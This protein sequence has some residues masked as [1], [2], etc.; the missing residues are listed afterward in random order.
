MIE[1]EVVGPNIEGDNKELVPDW[2]KADIKG[3]HDAIEA[4]DWEAELEGKSGIEKWEVVKRVIQEETDRCVPK[5]MRRVGSKPL[6]MN[7]N[8]LRLIRKKR[9]MWKAYSKPGGPLPE[10]GR[11]GGDYNSYSAY[12]KVQKEVQDSVKRAKKKLER[13]LAKNRKKNSKSFY[14][15]IKK[16]TKNKVTIGPL[17]DGDQNVTDSEHMANLLNKWYCSVFTKENLTNIPNPE[18]S[19]QGDQPLNS[20]NFTA[21]KVKKN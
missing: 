16:K 17:K 15:Y 5:K 2:T 19:Y 14:S 13:R 6:W 8:V 4:L 1:I 10:G 11:G 12:K 3:I 18:M 7:R 21:G 20:V 9:R